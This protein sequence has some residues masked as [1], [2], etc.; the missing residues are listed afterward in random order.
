MIRQ[1]LRLTFRPFLVA[2]LP[3][4]LAG[5]ISGV[6]V[7]IA[8][9]SDKPLENVVVSGEGFRE[10]VG[11][12]RPGNTETVFVRPRHE[13]I[14]RISFDVGG[15]DYSARSSDDSMIENDDVNRV[16]VK[17]GADFSVAVNVDLR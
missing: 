16:D 6:P 13:T 12:I 5:C 9:G 3:L 4:L 1:L 17:V 15:Q 10:S 7:S 8:N 14:V 2:V 11:T